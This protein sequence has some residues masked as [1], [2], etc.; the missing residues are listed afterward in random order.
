VSLTPRH[1]RGTTFPW[2]VHRVTTGPIMGDPTAHIE[3]CTVNSNWS[4]PLNPP[5][6]D[7]AIK[8]EGDF[9]VPAVPTSWGKIKTIYR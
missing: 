5:T 8:I 7:Y 2:T 3:A 1:S 4:Y 9:P 6:Y